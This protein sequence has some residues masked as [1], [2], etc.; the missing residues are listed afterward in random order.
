MLAFTLVLTP[1]LTTGCPG[2]PRPNAGPRAQPG[3]VA[4]GEEKTERALVAAEARVR[5]SPRDR[6]AW[7]TLRLAAHR[8]RQPHRVLLALEATEGLGRLRRDLWADLA[9]RL[10]RRAQNLARLGAP[11]AALR[12]LARADRLAPP[13]P[14]R[15]ASFAA[16]GDRLR[17]QR[18]DQNLAADDAAAARKVYR[19][20]ARRAVLDGEELQW[21]LAALGETRVNLAV[22][23]A[24]RH[25]RQRAPGP[26]QRLARVYLQIG[27]ADS[28]TLV[29]ALEA[30]SLGTDARLVHGLDVRLAKVAPLGL[31]VK[32]CRLRRR[33]GSP[34]CRQLRRW[35]TT[36]PR[37][38][39]PWADLCRE[40][41][42]I[43]GD[44]LW[45]VKAIGLLTTGEGLGPLEGILPVNLARQATKR[46]PTH[47]ALRRMAGHTAKLRQD[48]RRPAPITANLTNLLERGFEAWAS[49]LT[50]E[51]DRSLARATTMVS[52]PGGT[53]LGG[54]SPGDFGPR[55]Q[56]IRLT[57]R[58]R[59]HRAAY[60]LMIRL[61][62]LDPRF[63]R[64]LVEKLLARRDLV[65]AL[66]L[67]RTGHR[68]PIIAKLRDLGRI[69]SRWGVAK[70][71]ALRQR[72]AQR[73][74]SK[75]ARRA[76]AHVAAGSQTPGVETPSGLE[77]V[78][79][80]AGQGKLAQADARADARAKAKTKTASN[81]SARF[82]LW[83]GR[84]AHLRGDNQ[85]AL[86]RLRR[87]RH[88]D[89]GGFSGL[90]TVLPA[91]FR[92][93]YNRTAG[94]LAN[95]LYERNFIDPALLK[96]VTL[97]AVAAGRYDKAN[98][99][100]TDWA[101]ATGRPDRAYLTVARWLASRG[102]WNRAAVLSSRALGW[103]GGQP[104]EPALAAVGHQWAA[105][106]A[107]EAR[108][109]ANWL[110][111]RWPAGNSRL[112]I[113]QT[114]AASLLATH[115][116]DAAQP[117]MTRKRGL[118][119]PALLRKRRFAAVLERA[120]TLGHREPLASAWPGL[121]ALAAQGLGQ[122]KVAAR[123][124]DQV[125]RRSPGSEPLARALLLA[126]QGRIAAALATLAQTNLS[127]RRVRLAA[128]LAARG[129][130][131]RLAARLLS[132]WIVSVPGTPTRTTSPGLA[133]MKLLAAGK[134]L[135]VKIPW[136][137]LLASPRAASR[138][139]P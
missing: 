9:V 107:A 37:A 70:D 132:H 66:G 76:W 136:G 52:Q 139:E 109:T 43:P 25:L 78:L 49:G 20:L 116:L 86:R 117:Y 93:G 110:L 51:A 23:L 127:P 130:K 128:A 6:A 89:P 122:W 24:L 72:W 118:D 10:R 138:C 36:S 124:V 65:A 131:R 102:R 115:G 63:G 104:L 58:V 16:L 40:L 79:R 2:G 62:Q 11:H 54:R 137:V 22:A 120:T 32:A 96:L 31:L 114:L 92:Q 1:T 45:L 125:A 18:A 38:L 59:G 95:V 112:G 99:A 48:L 19:D 13:P 34:C 35:A 47:L 108:R 113:S 85:A 55:C 94:R 101:S 106:R 73:T 15:R 21:R 60:R 61:A 84:I 4:E 134:L 98:L 27:G 105:R 57:R 82:G 126:D 8:A 103:S 5:S 7:R 97:G 133:Q 26:A 53:S 77:Q 44:A 33:W 119:L 39:G 42:W 28:N 74:S 71:P 17:L 100:L 30:A 29:I 129:G 12:T 87:L 69:L 68:A 111:A 75:V 83:R 81:S 46:L 90:P 50:T 64:H 3:P 14:N 91:L 41:H 135:P 56:V 121:A 123:Y 88:Q 80:L 67:A